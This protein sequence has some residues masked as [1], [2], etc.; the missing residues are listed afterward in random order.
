MSEDSLRDG[1]GKEQESKKRRKERK[2]LRVR[3]WGK[4]HTERR[5]EG[6]TQLSGLS[7]TDEAARK[8]TAKEMVILRDAGK[9]THASDCSGSI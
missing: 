2:Q 7:D 9:H 1:R 6:T 5:D 4:E 3:D 8:I